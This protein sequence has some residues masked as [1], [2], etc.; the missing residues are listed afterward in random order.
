[1]KFAFWQAD[2]KNY[3]TEDGLVDYAMLHLKL[4]AIPPSG[5]GKIKLVMTGQNQAPLTPFWVL[6]KNMGVPSGGT[7]PTSDQLKMFLSDPNG[8]S[9]Q[10][11]QVQNANTNACTS[12]NG[13]RY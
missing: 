2:Q 12:D 1:M 9:S 10:V 4:T 11:S 5:Q 3:W 6:T 7:T 8:A 13:L